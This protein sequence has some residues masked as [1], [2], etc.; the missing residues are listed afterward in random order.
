MSTSVESAK[1]GAVVTLSSIRCPVKP[2]DRIQVEP[3]VTGRCPIP[4]RH[5]CRRAA[6][7]AAY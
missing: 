7:A 6:A 1:C 3:L 5:R 2:L 4:G